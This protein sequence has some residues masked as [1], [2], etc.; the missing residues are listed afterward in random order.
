MYN[1]RMLH[2]RQHDATSG[3]SVSDWLVQLKAG[4]EAA[5]Q[6]LWE[7][8]LT[9]LIRLASRRL[10]NTPRTV[11][12]SE[13]V[14]LSAFHALLDGARDGRFPRLADRHDL[15]QVVVMLVERKAIG[16]RRQ[17]LAGKRGAG[18]V[19]QE[20]RS[21]LASGSPAVG[22][23]LDQ[24]AHP[25]PTPQF[26]AAMREQLSARLAQLDDDVQRRIALGKL[27]GYTSAELAQS[28]G[29]SLRSVERKLA[30]IRRRFEEDPP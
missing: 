5:A 6:R 2:D 28:T 7:R 17:V 10:G 12:D 9:S 8:Y 24:I 26:A 13:D 22:S 27:A 20:R 15:W 21:R 25:D 29:L 16:Q 18:R 4:D 11:A 1:P 14:A 19:C 3:E 23:A 30:L